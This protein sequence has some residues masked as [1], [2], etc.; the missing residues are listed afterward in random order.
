MSNEST[1]EP[2]F[3]RGPGPLVGWFKTAFVELL[4]SPHGST[5]PP[6]HGHVDIFSTRFDDLFAG[7]SDGEVDGPKVDHETL[8]AKV[9]ALSG[10]FDKDS[11]RFER[12]K[13][14]PPN[15]TTVSVRFNFLGVSLS[16][17]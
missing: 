12:E 6:T 11:V 8:K 5:L 15:A 7:D 3:G 1:P 2:E 17:C 13:Q 16:R 9:S 4:T 10:H 14:E